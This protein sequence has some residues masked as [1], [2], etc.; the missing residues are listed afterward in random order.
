MSHRLGPATLG[1]FGWSGPR[2]ATGAACWLTINSIRTGIAE[3]TRDTETS[4][5]PDIGF[6]LILA[7]VAAVV[8]WLVLTPFVP[9]VASASMHRFHLRSQSFLTWAVQFPIPTMYNFSNR[10]QISE[11][12]PDLVDPIII[13]SDKRYINH[14][15]VRIFTFFN[16]RY[17]YLDAGTDRWLTVD[18]TYRGQRIE[19]NFH[20]RAKQEGAGF[21]LLRLDVAGPDR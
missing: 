4:H 21:D 12:P 7:L 10:Y 9:A 13:E 17:R 3:L 1:R 18:T 5:R 19:S 11:V 16:T 6:R 8:V 15:P 14:F 2:F 20:A